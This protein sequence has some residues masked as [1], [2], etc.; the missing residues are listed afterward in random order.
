M[1]FWE[2]MSRQKEQQ[3]NSPEL[4]LGMSQELKEG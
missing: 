1:N 2:R 4:E 3:S